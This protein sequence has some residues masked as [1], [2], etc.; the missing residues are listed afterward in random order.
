MARTH[1]RE[2]ATARTHILLGPAVL[3]SALLATAAVSVIA[4]THVAARSTART[5][6]ALTTSTTS[7][8]TTP[9]TTPG[10]RVVAAF[11]A[12]DDTPVDG[13]IAANSAGD[14]WAVLTGTSFGA[15][16]HWTGK[17]WVKVPLTSKATPYVESAVAFGGDSGRDFWLFS[18]YR[19]AQALRW[20]GTAWTVS[21]IPSWVLP[22]TANGADAAVFGPDDVWVFHFGGAAYA[23][24]DNGHQWAKVKLPAAVD[25]VSAVAADDIWALAGSKAL[26]WNG[27]AWAAI[28]IPAAAGSLGFLSATGP[29]S[30]WVLS[31][32]VLHWNGTKWQHVAGNPADIVNSAAPDGAGGLWATGID[33]NPGGFDD[34]YHLTG[35]HWA[36]AE[37]PAGVFNHASE[38]LTWIPGTRSLW[39]VAT[40]ATAT[41]TL[42]TVILKY[43][44]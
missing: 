13:Q 17:A 26:H 6:S 10:W 16:Y 11:P 42:D 29:K 22:N 21:A 12:V 39:G 40:G 24:H 25:E 23:A 31:A 33:I 28:K 8:G 30:A 34:F 5:T 3:A 19:P 18:S 36:Q 15:V 32:G 27:H 44:P 38:Y 7:G 14:A 9:A 4:G 35:S 1:R 20:T 41:G 37:N 43:G 2:P